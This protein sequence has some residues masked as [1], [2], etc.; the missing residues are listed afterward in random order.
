MKRVALACSIILLL[1]SVVLAQENGAT[2]I[3]K[4]EGATFNFGLLSLPGARCIGPA[5][6]VVNDAHTLIHGTGELFLADTPDQAM[7]EERIA[8]PFECRLIITPSGHCNLTCK[9][10]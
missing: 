9:T 10:P 5:T 3:T 4:P 2:V 6:I 7:H 1:A 8:G